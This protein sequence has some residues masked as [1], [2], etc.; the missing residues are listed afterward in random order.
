MT[1]ITKSG[2]QKIAALVLSFAAIFTSQ[3]SDAQY[4]K[5]RG[6]CG[7]FLTTI[8]IG[9]VSI[10]LDRPTC[11]L[12]TGFIYYT[13]DTIYTTAGATLNISANIQGVVNCGISAW[14][15][16]DASQSFEQTE[17]LVVAAAT[18]KVVGSMVV[19]PIAANQIS[20][21]RFMVYNVPDVPDPCTGGVAYGNFNEVV[22]MII[23]V[24]DTIP[25]TKYCNSTGNCGEGEIVRVIIPGENGQSV[26][27]TSTGCLGYTNF[28]DKSA[29]WIPNATYTVKSYLKGN[30]QISGGYLFI[31]WNNNNQLGDPGEQTVGVFNQN[32]QVSF[33][34]LVP[35]SVTTGAKRMRIVS[36]TGVN[37]NSV[38]GPCEISP[39]EGEVED[40]TVIF[41][42]DGDT[43][44]A[45]IEKSTA[46][47]TDSAVNVCNGTTFR[48]NKVEFATS[49]TFKLYD[50]TGTLLQSLVTS[51]TFCIPSAYSLGL[52]Y[53]WQVIAKA[54]TYAAAACDT[55]T[56]VSSPT[57]NP[58]IVFE[59]A[60]GVEVCRALDKT[61]NATIVNG[62][63]PYTYS[64]SGSLYAN[65]LLNDTAVA[66]PVFNSDS[67][68]SFKYR[69]TVKD[70]VGCSSFD[71]MAVEVK[72][73]PKFGT[74]S[75]VK[76][77]ICEGEAAL[78]KVIG[79]TGTIKLLSS[80]GLNDFVE[81][82]IHKQNDTLYASDVVTSFTVFR[83]ISGNST[84]AD[85]TP[86]FET[87][88]FPLPFKPTVF[89]SG[90]GP[91]CEG[92]S[93]LI[94][95]TNYSA[96]ITWND[97]LRT[98]NIELYI[99]KTGSYVATAKG[100]GGC[101][102][103]SDPE[104]VVINEAPEKAVISVE[105][106]VKPCNGDTLILRSSVSNNNWSNGATADSVVV[107]TSG[108]F[109][110]TRTSAE[111]CSS[112]SASVSFTFNPVPTK[113]VINQVSTDPACEGNTVILKSSYLEFNTWSDG[114]ANDFFNATEDGKYAVLYTDT[115]SGC[116]AVSDT[117][118][119]DFQPIP[120]KPSI[121][122]SGYPC[123]GQTI[124]IYTNAADSLGLARFWNTF[125]VSDTIY[126][127]TS[128]SFWLSVTDILGCKNYSDTLS[129]QFETPPLKPSITS[130]GTVLKAS[131]IAPIYRWYQNDVLVPGA[132]LRV[133]D[134]K[135][136]GYFRV[137]AVSANGCESEPSD[138]VYVSGV[139]ISENEALIDMEVYPNPSNGTFNI[140]LPKTMS[141]TLTVLDL[142]GRLAFETK[143]ENQ[144]IQVN[145]SLAKG[146]YVLMITTQGAQQYGKIQ[147]H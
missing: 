44:P 93:I 94:T 67:L 109:S 126:T 134:A 63:A 42:N 139:G 10:N 144:I 147:I 55:L 124:Q 27:N 123:L 50:S 130:N 75:I 64:W 71:S 11:G 103:S 46:Y 59:P 86:D 83:V 112:T 114:S 82:P 30:R 131:T 2:T 21:I 98:E 136:G 101:L 87:N 91:V 13:Q 8:T 47:P 135:A 96:D 69:F 122:A 140:R 31:D 77:E 105:G 60:S 133:F 22:D 106:K 84:C 117:F 121:T 79:A 36:F 141:G 89:V 142:S 25:Q 81:A 33:D 18:N 88:V 70:A 34:V 57:K 48:W 12:D 14:Y 37:A 19:S 16:A 143:F 90:S 54:G 85:T 24:V 28:T 9:S 45:C 41:K 74:I 1:A 52:R 119:V 65:D 40:Y 125:D 137:V 61:F 49:Y 127:D 80:D 132:S 51:D 53:K 107:T 95:V 99:K 26:D 6:D 73:E 111:G 38:T 62:T 15:D 118:S 120:A 128:G 5:G 56:F 72:P 17:K 115:A 110:I 43:I 58:E 116:T 102:N 97:T 20:R 129:L 39:N 92:D 32:Y 68:G 7:N 3:K 66:N 35:Q 104:Q 113:P 146:S 4:C 78:F 108:T 29:I 23:K 100:D 138:S 76:P 145:T